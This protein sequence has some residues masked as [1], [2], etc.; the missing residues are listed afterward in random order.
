MYRTPFVKRARVDSFVKATVYGGALAN[1][2]FYPNEVPLMAA[3]QRPLS[4]RVFSEPSGPP[5]WSTI[6]SWA[7]VGRND[8]IIPLADQI[9]MAERAGARVVEIDA[10]HLSIL[11][12]PRAVTDV[13]IKAARSF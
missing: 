12:D 11:T 1:E 5:A 2:G 7:V 8:R 4:T 6:S 9:S 13:V 3:S 10:P